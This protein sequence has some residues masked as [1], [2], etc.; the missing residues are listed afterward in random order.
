M[1]ESVEQF[2]SLRTS[3]NPEEY[4]RA[5]HEE[6]P[7]PVWRELIETHPDMRFWVAQ[8]K[9]VPIEILRSLAGDKDSR[10]RHMVAS[11]RKLPEDLQILLARDPDESVRNALAHNAKLTDEAKEI[12]DS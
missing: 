9:T 2:I 4:N 3:E 10:V 5:A 8:N 12:L 1:I 6:A 11:K 7:A